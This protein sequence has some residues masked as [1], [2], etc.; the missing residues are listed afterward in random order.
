MTQTVTAIRY[1]TPLREG[2][3]LPAVV[4]ADDGQL[5]VL[6]FSGAGQGP[7]ALIAELIAGEIGQ[8]LGLR[9]PRMVLVELDP[10]FGRT[11]PD[12]EIRELLEKST[13][14][15]LGF[16]YLANAFAF[17]P[18]L[19]PPPDPELASAIVWFDA[20]LTNV[21]RTPRNV[22]LL[23]W[24]RELWLIDHGACLYFHYNWKSYREHSRS[25]F[26]QICEHTLLPF[27]SSLDEADA[28]SRARL[29]PDIIERVVRHIPDAWLADEAQF[30]SHPD[31]RR[32]YRSFLQNRLEAS[33]VFVD[34]A[35]HARAQLF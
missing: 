32:A 6:K 1:V 26:P 34:E 21:D 10:A 15:N 9:V 14:L 2:S 8:A 24:Q 27:A 30:A 13:G 35:K 12:P 19:E 22:N 20:Y 4:E 3:S 23:I 31:H 28:L 33:E 7:K 17:N 18:L 11:E 5:Y 29:S 16:A 25:A